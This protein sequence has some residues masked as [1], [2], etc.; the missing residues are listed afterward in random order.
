MLARTFP[1]LLVLAACS[2]TVNIKPDDTSASTSGRTHGGTQGA[3]TGGSTAVSTGVG[4]SS[5][6][7]T[8]AGGGSSTTS[9]GAGAGACCDVP[10]RMVTAELDPAQRVSGVVQGTSGSDGPI[11][12]GPFFL[13]DYRSNY[14]A[15]LVQTGTPCSNQT[16]QVVG[17]SSPSQYLNG[18]R[19]FVPA[20]QTLCT[21]ATGYA[22]FAGFR[23]Y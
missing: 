15:W 3:G 9:T 23:P 18:I 20:G 8:G 2:G 7:S 1:A 12:D 5:S 14:G 11:A 4:S 16:Q 19:F 10:Q 17:P 13:T 22:Y 21:D 6:T